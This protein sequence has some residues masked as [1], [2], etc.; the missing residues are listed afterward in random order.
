MNFWNFLKSKTFWL[1]MAIA[2]GVVVV[3][4]FITN[5]I[6]GIYTTSGRTV[7]V[8][9]LVGRLQADIESEVRNGDLDLVLLDSIYRA[10]EQPGV[11]V[12]QIPA[13]G[14]K[15]KKGRT[16][17]ITINA[18]G[19]EMTSMPALV[20]YSFRNAK[21]NLQ[22]AGLVLG[23]VDSVPSPY[24]GL[25]LKQLKGGQ[26]VKAGDRLPKG[27]TIDLVVGRGTEG[28]VTNIPNLTGRLYEDALASLASAGLS[29]G[30]V[31]CDET[32]TTA[33]DSA[34]AIVYRQSPAADY[35]NS[36]DMWTPVSLWLTTDAT[37]A[38]QSVLDD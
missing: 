11:I 38:A 29:L 7:V 33:S 9:D 27:T 23:R 31:I 6:L 20:N 37:K 4:L 16:I 8:P 26:P 21:V 1:Q 22:N 19:K 2:A 32:V 18:F 24:D 14:K 12:D 36:V 13:A 17:Y 30:G 5:W 35:S 25:V 10:D 15:V 3:L 28:G 34:N